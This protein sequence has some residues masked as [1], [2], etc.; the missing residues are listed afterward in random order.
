[1]ETLIVAVIPNYVDQVQAFVLALGG[2]FAGGVLIAFLAWTIAF[3]VNA[4]YGW[5]ENWTR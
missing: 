1:M 5:L 4:V 2:F 3:T